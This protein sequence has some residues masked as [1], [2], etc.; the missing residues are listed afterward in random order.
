PIALRYV[1]PRYFDA[2]G[3]PIRAGRVFTDA[4][5][6]ESTPV[7]L[8][9]ETLAR[10]Q[11]PGIDPIGL[12]TNRG[13]IVGIVGDVRQVNLDRPADP[14]LYYPAAQNWS[15]VSELGMSLVV[16]TEMRP[17]AL[18]PVVRSIAG[19]VNPNLAIF[20]MRTMDGVVADSLADFTVYLSLMTLF[21]ALGLLL[22]VTGT[23]GVI[24]YTARS[25][26]REFAIRMALG[27]DNRRVMRSVLGQGVRLTGLGIGLGLLGVLAGAP[28][29][30]NLPVSVRPPDIAT[31]APIALFIGLVAIAA[32]LIPARRA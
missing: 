15:Q 10:R 4:D 26:T 14:E 7:V 21:A 22:A 29:L 25:R 13:T 11:F 16:R 20:N 31:A 28:L 32:C 24:S 3:I 1:T 30:Q 6:R 27:A 9:N 18:L 5:T 23:Y 17:E 2:L 8:V 12:A 19:Q